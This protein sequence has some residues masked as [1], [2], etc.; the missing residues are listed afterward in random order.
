MTQ[1][2]RIAADDTLSPIR[3]LGSLTPTQ[4]DQIVAGLSSLAQAWG[5]ERHESCNGHLSLVIGNTAS[6]ATV[7][8]DRDQAGIH[9]GLLLGDEFHPSQHR[10]ATTGDAVAAIKAIAAAPVVESQRN[11]G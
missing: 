9:V 2:I 11:A 4:A 5:I 8:V 6:D 7:I 10:Y 3:A 1:T